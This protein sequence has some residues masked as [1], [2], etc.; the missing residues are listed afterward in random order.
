MLKSVTRFTMAG[1][2]A[3]AIGLSGSAYAQYMGP[4]QQTNVSTVAAV[5]KSTPDDHDVLLRGK[6]TRKLNHEHYEFKD[7]TG[8]IRLEIDD[9][10]FHNVKVTADTVIEIYGEM[11]KDFMESPEIEVKR[12]TI[13]K[14]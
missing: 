6:I 10:Y 1:C 4:G 11:E 13:I 5:L 2:A 8:T 14:P 7:N 12:L 9:S 3:L